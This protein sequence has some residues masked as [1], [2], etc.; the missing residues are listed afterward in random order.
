M[1]G[2]M[3][4]LTYQQGS[5]S[6]RRL[7]IGFSYKAD[8]KLRRH[9]RP[10]KRRI[11]LLFLAL[12][13]IS[14]VSKLSAQA[15]EFGALNGTV[16]DPVGHVIVDATVTAT[17]TAT[18]GSQF[19]KTNSTGQYRIFHL[20]PAHYS[21]TFTASGFKTVTIEPFQLNVGETLTQDRELPIGDT[22]Q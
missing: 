14:L 1:S 6:G 22:A 7:R 15:T 17:N 16:T 3:D 20:L 5:S 2:I 13:A 10:N 8:R 12:L 11:E 19:A 18:N 9:L 21:L 4:L